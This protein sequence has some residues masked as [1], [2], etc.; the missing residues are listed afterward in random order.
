MPTRAA[1]QAHAHFG[2]GFTTDALSSLRHVGVGSFPPSACRL[3]VDTRQRGAITDDGLHV[4]PCPPRTV[5][6]PGPPGTVRQPRPLHAVRR[7]L[8]RRLCRRIAQ[9]HRLQKRSRPHADAGGRS[10]LRIPS[11]CHF[12]RSASSPGK[13]TLQSIHC[14]G[15]GV[16]SH[17][18]ASRICSLFTVQDQ[19]YVVHHSARS[20]GHCQGVRDCSSIRPKD[21]KTACRG[22]DCKSSLTIV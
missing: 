1:N 15:P 6:H 20:R 11:S 2:L 5:R 19:E 9:Y 4:T 22:Q 10:T 21:E 3:R 13:L 16:C 8:A 12:T 14:P 17:H 18:S 7:P